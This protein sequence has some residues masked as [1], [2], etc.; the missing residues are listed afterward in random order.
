MG[1]GLPLEACEEGRENSIKF[2][3]TLTDDPIA[4]CGLELQ[5]LEAGGGSEAV[6]ATWDRMQTY[7]EVRL[8]NERE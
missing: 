3:A 7:Y 8:A 6:R 4:F 1:I 5:L 2:V